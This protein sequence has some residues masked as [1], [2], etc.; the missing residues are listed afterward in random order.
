MQECAEQLMNSKRESLRLKKMMKSYRTVQSQIEQKII[1]YMEWKQ[2]TKLQVSEELCCS[3]VMKSK[4]VKL[5]AKE[6]EELLEDLIV[7]KGIS[8]LS[9][10]HQFLNNCSRPDVQIK[11][12]LIE[13][14]H[15][16][17]PLPKKRCIVS[18]VD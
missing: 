17:T 18:I 10:Y 6:R 4:K 2:V 14:K 7:E 15:S 16:E 3:I 5:S 11:T 8:S 13:Y 1:S 12:L 9:D